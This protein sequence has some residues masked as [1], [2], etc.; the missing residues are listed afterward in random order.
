M[1]TSKTQST[2]KPIKLRDGAIS[3]AIWANESEKGTFY[4]VTI[5]RTYK[6]GEIFRDINSYSG[7]ELLKVARLAS[8]AYDYIASKRAEGNTDADTEEA[9]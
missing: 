8:L 3:A 6:E 4:S 9:Q 7:T 5:S 1:T 2:R